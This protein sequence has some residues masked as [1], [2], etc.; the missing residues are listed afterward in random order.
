M[1]S[2]TGKTLA[3]DINCP[4]FKLFEKIKL[5]LYSV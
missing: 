3:D 4:S 2:L 1:I 5:N